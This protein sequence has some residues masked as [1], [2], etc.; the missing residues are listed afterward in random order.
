MLY[1]GV[2]H[3]NWTADNYGGIHPGTASAPQL[4]ADSSPHTKGADTAVMNG[5]AYDCW[6]LHITISTGATDSTIRRQMIDLLIDPAAGVGNAGSSWT[7]LISNI[8]THCPVLSASAFLGHH[9]SFPLFIPAGTALGARVQD[10]VADATCRISIR[11]V[12]QPTRPDLVKVGHKVQTIGATEASTDGVAFTPGNSAT[13]SYSSSM[14]TLTND[15]WWWQVG[16]G[17]ADSTL[18]DRAMFIDVAHDATSKYL[19]MTQVPYQ[20]N[21]SERSSKMAYG[22]FLPIRHAPAGTDVYIRAASGGA[23]DPNWTGVV[24]A[25]T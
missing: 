15:A 5:L 21:S 9:F 16:V 19:C 12:G 20:Q 17:T 24:Y 4:T 23:P 7:E 18:T 10:V 1:N 6:G 22:E 3:F 8:Y 14:G 2:N 25:V 13:G 11:V